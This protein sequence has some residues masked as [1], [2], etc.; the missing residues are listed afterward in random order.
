MQSAIDRAQS[1]LPQDMT[2]PPSYRKVNPADAPVLLLAVK[3]DVAPLTDLDAIAQQV[4]SPALSTI[5]GVAQI[6]INGS[7]EYAVRIQIDPARLAA[8]GIS[9]TQLR[10]AITSANRNT[11]LGT[12]TAASQQ[13]TLVAD[14]QLSNASAF[15]QQVIAVRNGNP[16]RLGD[17]TR[18]IDSVANNQI[19][20]WHDGSRAIVLSVQRQPDANTVAVVDQVRAMLPSIESQLPGTA[21]IAVLNDRSL[22]I[23]AA[24][25]DAEFTLGLTLVLVILVI[26]LFIRSVRATLI[27]AV[28]VPISLIGTLGT[29]YLLGFSIDNV[30]LMGLTLAIGLVVDDAIVMM[31]NI[32]RHMEE[33]GTDA[34]AAALAGSG[35]IGFTIISISLSLVAVFI[36]VLLMGGVIGR[37]FNE[38][39]VVVTVS[40][41]IS[42]FVSLTLTAMMS[43]RILSA[44][45]RKE[46][47]LSAAL[48]RG[49]L[50]LTAGYAWLLDK[51]LTF[52]RT[53][54]T[55]FLATIMASWYLF[56]I[57][58]KGFFPQED[59]GQLQV[60]T[61]ARQDI[62]F[63]AME[64]LQAQVANIFAASPYVAHVASIVGSTSGAMNSGRLF[65]ELKPKAE[66][67]QLQSVLT[68]LRAKLS[69][70]PGITAFMSPVQNLS[71][72]ARSS[73][74]QYQIT[75]QSIDPAAT[76]TWS[77]KLMDAMKADHSFFTDVT[78]DLQNNGLQARLVIDRDKAAALGISADTLRG[79]LYPVSARSRSR[80]STPPT[81]ATRSLLNSIPALTGRLSGSRRSK[82][83]MQAEH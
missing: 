14:T 32:V 45:H 17:V 82:S 22:S 3:S 79:T 68:S 51:S 16:V 55:L 72:G 60:T 19:A 52:H 43:S 10:D 66:R 37:I 59:I 69:A 12:L 46:T 64:E 6:Q 21:S 33:D 20:A 11:P 44:G 78:S 53:V 61:Q 5:D 56:G 40:I 15:A 1:T 25:S 31:E 80:R 30:S 81:T 13:L 70:V 57:L 73:A 24:I 2:S 77:L 47:G 38:F 63:S 8:K 27:P 49:L 71:I 67:P 36:P 74:S 50:A 42:M 62:S 41:L 48:E 18:V 75:V 9:I 65:V 35:E 28:A 4:I 29:M 76:N 83:G 26:Y 34:F 58:P 23:R 7:Q 54:F 39:A